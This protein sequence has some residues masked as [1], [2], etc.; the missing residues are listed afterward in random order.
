MEWL[1]LYTE[2]STDPKVQIMSE[3]MQRRLIML[4]CIE[5]SNGIETF[6]VTDRDDSL[7]FAMRISRESLDETKDEFLRRGFINSDWTL[8]NWNKR[9]YASDSS[10]ERVKRH[11][12]AKKMADE[13]ACNNMKRFSNSTEQNRTDTEQ[14]KEKACASTEVEAPSRSDPIPYQQIVDAYNRV[15]DRLPKVREMTAKRKTLVRSA[16]QASHQR[17]TLEFWTAYFEECSDDKFLNG[18]GPYGNGHDNWRPNF[19]YL[20]RPDVVT[21]TFEKAMDRMERGK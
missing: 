11:R 6:H 18:T 8:R 15:M 20:V 5:R 9:Q 14:I 16:W 19:D 1:R 3:A 12:E 2:F 10:T 21:R 4:F 17:R 13:T 7:C